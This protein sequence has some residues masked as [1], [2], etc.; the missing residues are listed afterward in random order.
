LS[1]PPP[2]YAPQRAFPPYAYVPGRAPHPRRDPEGHSHELAPEPV[3][4]PDA[5][6]T[7]PVFLYSVDLFNHGYFWEAHE[8]WEQL[9]HRLAGDPRV[10]M[11]CLIK[12]AAACVKVKQGQLDA[13]RRQSAAAKKLLT[14]LTDAV[15]PVALHDLIALA[16]GLARDPTAEEL[17]ITLRITGTAI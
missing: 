12:L 17:R 14:S 10:L 7:S 15:G 1:T 8:G 6:P 2:R 9:W 11:K 4:D 16:D 5:W 13:A 3:G